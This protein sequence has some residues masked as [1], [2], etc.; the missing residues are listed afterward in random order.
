[1]RV[2]PHR[3]ILQD[4]EEKKLSP[5]QIRDYIFLILVFRGT[6]SNIHAQR[7]SLEV[8]FPIVVFSRIHL[9]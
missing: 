2:C 4:E 6:F 9:G 8:N 5:T 1:M 3:Q 7:V